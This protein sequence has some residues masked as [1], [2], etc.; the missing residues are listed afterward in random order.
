MTVWDYTECRQHSVLGGSGNVS[1]F[2]RAQH[3]SSSEKPVLGWRVLGLCHPRPMGTQ[4]LC[5]MWGTIPTSPWPP[6]QEDAGGVKV[7][8]PLNLGAV[9][10]SYGVQG[11][12]VRVWN[13]LNEFENGLQ[14]YSTS[15]LPPPSEKWVNGCPPRDALWPDRIS[16]FSGFLSLSRLGSLVPRA[17]SGWGSKALISLRAYHPSLDT[18]SKE[19]RGLKKLNCQGRI[20]L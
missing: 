12:G 8:V 11:K 6:L 19:S 10:L 18:K 20:L 5:C 15:P 14:H 3:P 2:R 1:S 17:G 13:L 4:L 7:S 16:L 9:S